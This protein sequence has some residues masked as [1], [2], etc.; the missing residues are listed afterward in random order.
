MVLQQTVLEDNLFVDH[1]E[2]HQ[3]FGLVSLLHAHARLLARL[4][5]E[6]HE[7]ECI[8]RLVRSRILVLWGLGTRLA[9]GPFRHVPLWL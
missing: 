3:R 1:R 4:Q 8:G 2:V 5:D 9:G 6:T 7:L